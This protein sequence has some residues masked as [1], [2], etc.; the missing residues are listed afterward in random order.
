MLY[1]SWMRTG[2]SRK[3][4]MS[5]IVKFISLA[6]AEPES[7]EVS[8]SVL[9]Q[10]QLDDGRLVVVLDDRGWS[11]NCSWPQAVP[12]DIRETALVV[13]GPDEPGPGATRAQALHDY[14][15]YI[16][17]ILAAQQLHLPVHELMALEHE[18][19]FGPRLQNLLAASG[20]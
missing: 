15:E 8:V 2:I 1:A 18:V 14:W 12:A 16:Q 6:E 20:H 3:D 4:T 9:L 11:T 10:A 5:T 13:A 17:T 7:E 19:Q